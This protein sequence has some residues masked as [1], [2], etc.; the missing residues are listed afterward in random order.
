MSLIRLVAHSCNGEAYPA[1]T[2]GSEVHSCACVS[3]FLLLLSPFVAQVADKGK[4][5]PD[6]EGPTV[7]KEKGSLGP[8]SET[9]L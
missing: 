8:L 7:L 1:D 5:G 2:S 4:G 3:A 9:E 6:K